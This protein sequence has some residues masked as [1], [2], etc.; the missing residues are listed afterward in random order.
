MSS[1][2]STLRTAPMQLLLWTANPTLLSTL[3]ETTRDAVDSRP[4]SKDQRSA[5]TVMLRPVVHSTVQDTEVTVTEWATAMPMLVPIA[6]LLST[7]DTSKLSSTVKEREEMP[8][9][10]H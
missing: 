6:T 2:L 10:Q 9:R 4:D 8:S 5:S 1:L 3:T 7:V